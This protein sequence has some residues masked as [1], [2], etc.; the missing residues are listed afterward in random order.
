[1]T[2]CI[3]VFEFAVGVATTLR[4]GSVVSI[5]FVA[6]PLIA[7]PIVEPHGISAVRTRKHPL[8]ITEQCARP[9]YVGSYERWIAGAFVLGSCFL[10]GSWGRGVFLGGFGGGSACLGVFRVLG[11]LLVRSLVGGHGFF[12]GI[13][14]LSEVPTTRSDSH[15]G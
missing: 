2:G 13:I 11:V 14:P 10:R 7:G 4:S 3:G 12:V 1:M 9:S 15:E 5:G 6:A 8:T